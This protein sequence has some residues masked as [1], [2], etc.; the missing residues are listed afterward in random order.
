M[1]VLIL[2]DQN[3]GQG[4]FFGMNLEQIEKLIFQHVHQ[5]SLRME[6]IRL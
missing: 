5:T 2:G 6:F 3:A 4:F 1:H